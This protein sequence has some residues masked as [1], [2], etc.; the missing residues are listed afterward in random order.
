M[1]KTAKVVYA[2]YF[3]ISVTVVLNS[4]LSKG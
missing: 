3:V 1:T 2:C 4:Y